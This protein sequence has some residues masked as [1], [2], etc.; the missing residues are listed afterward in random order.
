MAGMQVRP[1]DQLQNAAVLSFVMTACTTHQI[2][3]NAS[4]YRSGEVLEHFDLSRDLRA[5]RI[6]L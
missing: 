1:S 3:I 6:I 4:S 5:S 2:V